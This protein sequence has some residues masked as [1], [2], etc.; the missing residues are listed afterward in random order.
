MNT[1]TARPAN[2]WERANVG[3]MKRRPSSYWERA[4]TGSAKKANYWE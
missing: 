4:K 2:Y 3:S 1:K